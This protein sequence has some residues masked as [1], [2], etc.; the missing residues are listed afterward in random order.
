[1]P[2]KN[3]CPTTVRD[4]QVDVESRASTTLTPVWLR[5]KGLNSISVSNDADTEDGS[6]AESLFGEPYV[7]K[8][9]GSISLEGRPVVDRVTGAH[10]PGQEELDYY[11][12]VGGCDGDARIR[13]IDNC[14]HAEIWD[15]I[16][17]SKET[18]AD[19]TSE[20]V[21]WELER[22]GEPEEVPYVQVTGIATSPATSATVTIGTPTTVTVSFT[23]TG[24]SNQKYSV[25]S[26]DTSKV[27]VKN[28]DG[29][30]FD[31]VGVA[32][33]TSTVNVVVK[34]MNNAKTATI[35]VTVNE[36]D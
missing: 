10:D 4:W 9:N 25:A 13:I 30:T 8:R 28:I 23:P 16:V 14:G 29:L 20:T 11:L 7:T 6:S 15:V 18:S 21:T 22:V 31:L 35:A 3:G 33:T 19:D 32:Q 27:Q 24:A 17:V 36:A 5:V 2:R 12:S 34:S 26:A 1:M